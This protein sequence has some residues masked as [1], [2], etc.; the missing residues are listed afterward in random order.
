[1]K[2]IY[3]ASPYTSYDFDY[4]KALQIKEERFQKVCKKAADLMKEGYI[5]FCPIAHS[6]P[7]DPCGDRLPQ[8]TSFWMEQDLP[9]LSYVD[10]LWVYKLPGWE[11]S[12][13]VREEIRFAMNNKKPVKWI[14]YVPD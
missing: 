6:H 13:G 5:V 10:E 8:T 14:E 2:F 11:E 12:K 3:L 4:G 7:I 1:M 9:I